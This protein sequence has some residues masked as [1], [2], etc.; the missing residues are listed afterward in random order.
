VSQTVQRIGVFGGTFD[1]IHFAHLRCAEEVR[2]TLGLDRVLFMPAARPPH[3]RDHA[4]TPARHRLAMVRLAVR[5]HPFFRASDL[6]IARGGPSY[7]V[8]TLRALHA[9][10]GRASRFTLLIGAD[11]FLE[12]GTWHEYRQL[13]ALAD[14]AV[15]KRP[16]F[17]V[18]S[19]RAALPVAA[20]GAFCYSSSRNYLI[21]ETGNEI[22]FLNVTALDISASD[23]RK[24]VQRGR[25]ISFLTP[26]SV[27]RYLLRHRLYQR[28]SKPF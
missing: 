11:A 26:R 19:L 12:I 4:I 2:E 9:R 17:R 10:S 18:R 3:K 15:M 6:E 1:P 16:T 7:S 24:R 22:H 13:F 8:D 28:G 14:L 27:E 5:G 23:I 20:R 25:S 21:H